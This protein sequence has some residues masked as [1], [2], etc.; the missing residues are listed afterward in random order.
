[1]STTTRN[2]LHRLLAPVAALAFSGA[3]AAAEPATLKL[4]VTDIEGME[5]LL[6]EWGPFKEALEEASGLKFEFYPVSSRTASAEALRAQR[7]DFAI[8]GPAEYI[9]INKLTD[10]QPLIGLGRPDYLCAIIVRADSGV[11]RPSDLKGKKVAFGD[12][13]STSTM[14][15]PMQLLADYG[16]EP[17]KDIE[18]IHTARNIA[19]EALKRGDIAAIGTNYNSWVANSRDKDPDVPPGFFRVIARSGD[20]PNDVIMVGSHV[21]P[22][23]AQRFRDAVIEAKAKVIEAIL[24]HDENVKYKGMDLVA[25]TDSDYDIVRSM[26]SVAGFPQFDAFIG[27]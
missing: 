25:V 18:K 12:I 5:R 3:V 1:M 20:L 13:G 14:L 10:A 11:V 26:Y 22:E 8:S 7:L 2:I 24:Q 17:T 15:C 6:T 9:V 16:V 19:H 21:D 4:A 23:I 27:E